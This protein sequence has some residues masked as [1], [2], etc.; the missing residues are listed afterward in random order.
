MISRKIINQYR[1]ESFR[2]LEQLGRLAF[3]SAEDLSNLYL[4]TL[5]SQ[6][7]AVHAWVEPTLDGGNTTA[8]VVDN[9][10]E[11]GR[12]LAQ[13][14]NNLGDALQLIDAQRRLAGHSA[15]LIIEDLQKWTPPSANVTVSAM[16]LAVDAVDLP[17]Q[18]IAEHVLRVAESAEARPKIAA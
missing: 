8:P 14:L 13:I 12:E 2:N 17:V 5:R 1:S 6:L 7:A 10:H 11:L 18:A 3:G 9:G 16:K 15:R 4:R